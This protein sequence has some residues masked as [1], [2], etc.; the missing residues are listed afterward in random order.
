MEKRI[1]TGPGAPGFPTGIPR[2]N[3]RALRLRGRTE[4]T[5]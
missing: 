3:T 2:R 4:D 5:A 1:E